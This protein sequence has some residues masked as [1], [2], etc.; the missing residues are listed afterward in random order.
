V[1][2]PIERA[3]HL[4][5]QF[6][7]RHSFVY[8]RVVSGL[9]LMLW[10]FFK[11]LVIADR[12]AIYVNDVYES[13]AAHSGPRLAVAT[14]FFA[15]QIYCDFSGYSDIAI[16]AARV[17]GF[18]L[19]PNFRR[20][21]HAAS[22]REFWH[23]WHISLSTWF[24]DYLYLPLGG[25]RVGPMRHAAN[26]F[27]VFVVSGLWH[28][29][30]WTF[31][32]WGAL[33]GLYVVGALATRGLRE[34]LLG[35][36]ATAGRGRRA[37]A[38]LQ[39]FLLVSFAWIFFRAASLGDALVA[40]SRIATGAD[41]QQP[42][43]LESFGAV[44]MALAVGFVVALELVQAAEARWDA[45]PKFSALPLSVRWACYYLLVVVVLL[46][47]KFDEREFIYFQF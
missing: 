43:L 39:T 15:Y 47:G 18:D 21:Y 36:P 25:N 26:L 16:G 40:V 29:A 9:R 1:A 10:G 14:V 7:E 5:P 8:G 35:P 41:W 13:P 3:T 46:F 11:K 2:G 30:S 37:V 22:I 12:L 31:V 28:G 38:V 20:P 32:I 4:L 23:R 17:M 24:R 27:A 19:A 6:F 44:E 34:R 33:H 45:G 42:V